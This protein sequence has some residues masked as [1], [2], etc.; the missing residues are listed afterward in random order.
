MI[1]LRKKR[2]VF[3]IYTVILVV[4][5][6]IGIQ[7]NSYKTIPA[8]ALPVSNKVIIIDAGHGAPDERGS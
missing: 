6:Y 8:I 7:K 5:I 3:I 4:F 1:I 2:L